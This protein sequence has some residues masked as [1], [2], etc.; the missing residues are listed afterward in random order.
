V[1]VLPPRAV[2]A[3][4]VES[5]LSS[6]MSPTRRAQRSA[7]TASRKGGPSE[8]APGVFVGGW[9]DAAQF[10]GTRICVLDEA[11]AEMPDATHVPIYDEGKDEAILANLERVARSVTSAHERNEPV[12]L[13]CGHGIRRSP[14]A[15]A[16]YL[17]RSEGLSLE[18]AY[19]RI[20]DTRPRIE[21]AR[22]WIGHT[23]NLSDKR[24]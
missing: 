22:D 2:S 10:T 8:I 5:D 3:L 1:L 14:L 12:L 4:I 20:R 16:W 6:P 13:F 23:E 24:K 19:A 18:E 11:P 9:K 17:H 15:G 21:P 7:P